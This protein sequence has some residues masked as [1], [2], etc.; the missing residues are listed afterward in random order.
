MESGLTPLRVK[1]I[2]QHNIQNRLRREA[3]RRTGM[4][5]GSEGMKAGW[6]Y[7]FRCLFFFIIFWMLTLGCRETTP[8]PK[9]ASTPPSPPPPLP[10]ATVASSV[11]GKPIVVNV[12]NPQLSGSGGKT[13]A[14]RDVILFLGVMYGNEPEGEKLLYQL[15][16]FLEEYRSKFVDK[17]VVLIPVVNPGGLSKGTP[18][19][20]EKVLIN[21]DFS[22]DKSADKNAD[23]KQKETLAVINT[24]K[25]Y[26]PSRVINV[27]CFSKIDYDGP[28]KREARKLAEHI[29]KYTPRLEIKDLPSDEGTLGQYCENVKKIPLITFGINRYLVEHGDDTIWALYGRSMLAAIFY[30]EDIPAEVEALLP[31]R[32]DVVWN[33]MP[34]P[35]PE[36]FD[37]LEKCLEDYTAGDWNRAK[38]CYESELEQTPDC[39]ECRNKIAECETNLLREAGRTALDTGDNP[40]AIETLLVVLEKDPDNKEAKR[41]ISKAHVGIGE[42][43]LHAGEYQKAIAHFR[44]TLKY[45][46]SCTACTKGI[47]EAKDGLSAYHYNI[48]LAH[49]KSAKSK[50]GNTAQRE[51]VAQDIGRCLA[52]WKQLK[53]INPEFKDISTKWGE[54][55]ALSLQ[56]N[57]DIGYEHFGIAGE[58]AG[59]YFKESDENAREDGIRAYDRCIEA[60]RRVQK[61][62]AG[63]KNIQEK[64]RIAK[65]YRMKLLK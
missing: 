48:G 50:E 38:D 52:A 29:K 32:R 58:K 11:K 27:R 3:V 39:A 26:K 60:W 18:A 2:K 53:G 55:E 21:R 23:K 12:L 46:K 31:K 24:I 51:S 45:D 35:E 19:N 34:A 10:R 5:G 42:N 20:S 1:C 62:D 15:Q 8:D 33:P 22:V 17:T 61:I 44:E 57:Y 16:K 9:P 30:P 65:E 59:R 54:A 14:A 64:I 37:P 25:D 36:T 28:D 43:A 63:Y 40:A 41:L 7:G 56:L 49:F 13:S 6:H 47:A 4:A